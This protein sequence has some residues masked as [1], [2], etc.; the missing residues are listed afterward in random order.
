MKRHIRKLLEK[1]VSWHNWNNISNKCLNEIYGM[2]E[3][4]FIK[5]IDHNYIIVHRWMRC[6]TLM[7]LFFVNG[8]PNESHSTCLK[9]TTH[10]VGHM[11]TWL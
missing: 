4:T 3:N 8:N 6:V 10:I 1:Q 5:G 2:H 9:F 7:K 11:E